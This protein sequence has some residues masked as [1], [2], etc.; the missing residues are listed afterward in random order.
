MSNLF[1]IIGASGAGKDSL[2]NHCR[3]QVNGALPIVFTHRYITRPANAGGENHVSLSNE[4]FQLRLQHGL[5][6][7]HWESH[8]LYY[9]I[10]IEINTWLQA[11][12][13]VVINGSREYLNAAVERY[14]SIQPI[15][16]EADAELIK[17]R[18]NGRGRESD[19]SI[20]ERIARN[21]Q[22]SLKDTG[23]IRIQNNGA[24][25]DAANELFNLILPAK[26]FISQN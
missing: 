21:Q 2:I 18:L 11:G 15:L 3:S 23:I 26:R 24:I 17:A 13:A 4:E 16:I 10:G 8:G 9:G 25:D 5:F 12:L 14:P 19:E 1:Y 6:A 20:G 7:L 22:L